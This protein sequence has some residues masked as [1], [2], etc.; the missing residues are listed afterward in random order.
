MLTNLPFRLAPQNRKA[1]A[2]AL[3]RFR[4]KSRRLR[5]WSGKVPKP[6]RSRASA[7]AVENFKDCRKGG[8][9]YPVNDNPT[10]ESVRNE[11]PS[12][13]EARAI[14]FQAIYKNLRVASSQG[15][16]RWV[17]HSLIMRKIMPPTL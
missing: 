6:R 12:P 11:S 10:P 9:P 4:A 3:F 17:S 14:T 1:L 16:R 15:K 2:I 8:A 5:L 13:F 7:A